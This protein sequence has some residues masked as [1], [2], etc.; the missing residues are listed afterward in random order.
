MKVKNQNEILQRKRFQLKNE[1]YKFFFLIYMSTSLFWYLLGGI[2]I[3]RVTLIT[4][5]ILGFLGYF[6]RE[7]RNIEIRTHITL[8]VCFI[9]QMFLCYL[10]YNSSLIC[11]SFLLLFPLISFLFLD[12]KG[13]VMW[14]MILILAVIS[15]PFVGPIFPFH[16][17]LP[18]E[19][20]E[21][22][23]IPHLVVMFFATFV[24]LYMY[25]QV[26]FDVL[27]S[28][29]NKTVKLEKAQK[30]KDQ[31]FAGVSHEL[32]TPMNA[33][34]GISN[35]LDTDYKDNFDL[36]KNLKNSSNHLLTIINDLLDFS[37]IKAGKLTL[38]NVVFNIRDNL[39][40]AFNIVFVLS[41][42]KKQNISLEIDKN[43]PSELVG[44]PNRLIQIVVN[45]LSNAAKYTAEKGDIF[46]KCTDTTTPKQ[47][48][49]GMC[50]F[51]IV[52]EDNGIGMN[53]ETLNNIYNEYF[54]SDRLSTEYVSGTGLG[55]S[56]TK[57]LLDIMH[58]NIKIES[59]ENVGTKVS[60]NLSFPIAK[61][62]QNT[63]KQKAPSSKLLDAQ[64]G[65]LIVDDNHL[66]LVVAQKQLERSMKVGSRI[67]TATNGRI[68]IEL[69]KQNDI[70]IILMDM[71]M[72][73][74][75]GVEATK[76]IRQLEDPAKRHVPIIA[77][78]ANVGEDSKRACLESGMNEYISK[79]FE[80]NSLMSKIEILLSQESLIE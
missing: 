11:I 15:M 24:M 53:E 40:S 72:P 46:I 27:D 18:K 3:S 35:L 67:Y 34:I 80:I 33:I 26:L 21:L 71:K 22:I 36:I 76:Q 8:T 64:K 7:I 78:T 25:R 60:L 39:H 47:K 14:S 75:D 65:I 48:A 55:L 73:V 44:D 10:T 70:D 54:R 29:Q 51:S 13:L 43:I 69:L 31:F 16:Y 37:S 17:P 38:N 61:K 30:N 9:S 4:G 52:V 79:P 59:E 1:A 32:R 50:S 42:E 56:I 77:M 49:S 5:I 28:L 45:I 12:N 57:N 2:I 62:E 41:Q 20:L 74:M 23:E 19:Y 6:G 68:A 66:N 63:I 58:G